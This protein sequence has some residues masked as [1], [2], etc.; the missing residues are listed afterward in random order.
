MVCF[1]SKIPNLGLPCNERSLRPFCLFY[2]HFV[3][4][5][6]IRYILWSFRFIFPVLVCCTKKNLA[7]LGSFPLCTFIVLSFGAESIHPRTI[8]PFSHRGIPGGLPQVFGY[9]Y[10]STETGLKKRE[11]TRKHYVT[12]SCR[13]LSD[14]SWYNTKIV[15]L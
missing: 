8:Y 10:L 11:K 1:Q 15:R 12:A 14:F 3:Y 9:V 2:C 6:A 13:M 5:L 4:F 7:T